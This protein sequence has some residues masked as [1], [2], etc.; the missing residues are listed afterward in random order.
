MNS[1]EYRTYIYD[2]AYLYFK[3][4]SFLYLDFVL[5]LTII[6]I[7]GVPVGV[8]QFEKPRASLIFAKSSL[9]ILPRCCAINYMLII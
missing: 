9:E 1:T 3:F 4:L 2:T 6:Q 8:P 7:V 5:R